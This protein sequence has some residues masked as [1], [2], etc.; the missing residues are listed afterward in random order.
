METRDPAPGS[1]H[2]LVF[3]V[4]AEA[5][6]RRAALCGRRGTQRLKQPSIGHV[7]ASLR[8]PFGGSTTLEHDR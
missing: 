1:C 2:D 8:G 7:Q 4:H 6:L 3:F 5:A